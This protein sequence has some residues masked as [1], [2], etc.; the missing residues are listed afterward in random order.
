MANGTENSGSRRLL[1][2][3]L[4]AMVLALAG[5]MTWGASGDDGS[6]WAYKILMGK[7]F[8]AFGVGISL[9]LGVLVL[10]PADAVKSLRGKLGRWSLLIGVLG[11]LGLAVSAS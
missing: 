11:S 2:W 3:G 1:W 9:L 10:A 5:A 8:F 4:A 7:V 6:I